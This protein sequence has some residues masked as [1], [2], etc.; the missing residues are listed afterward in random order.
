MKIYL[1]V[2]FPFVDDAAIACFTSEEQFPC[3]VIG[4]VEPLKQLSY[5]EGVLF[6]V[7]VPVSFGE[8]ANA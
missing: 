4:A 1:T 8:Y 5:L 7:I 3:I 6:M 2:M